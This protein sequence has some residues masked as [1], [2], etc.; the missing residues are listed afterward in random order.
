MDVMEWDGNDN[1]QEQQ[2][3]LSR[4]NAEDLVYGAATG[5]TS[6]TR[7]LNPDA[8]AP[9]TGP[10]QAPIPLSGA[11]IGPVVNSDSPFV[12]ANNPNNYLMKVEIAGI[13]DCKLQLLYEGKPM[14]SA[15][16]SG[17]VGGAEV[18][19]VVEPKPG[20]YIARVSDFAGCGP[21]NG[22]V[23]FKNTVGML[24]TKGSA[25]T[26]SNWTGKPTGWAIT[27]VGPGAFSGLDHSADAGGK[28]AITLDVV[29]VG[30]GE[31]DLSAGFIS[32]AT[33]S[34][35]GA[36]ALNTGRS[37][38]MTVPVFNNGGKAVAAAVVQVRS[39]SATGPVVATRTVAVP[40]YG[41]T[42]VA[43]AFT[44]AREGEVNLFTVV[45]PAGAVGEKTERNN[46]QRSTLWAGPSAPRVLVVDDDG[47]QDGEST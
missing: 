24:D 32:G 36:G 34:A 16:D 5:I 3:S 7:K 27:N 33:N 46:S 40:A 35:G 11:A 37:N 23:T 44:P 15:V 10:A 30:A 12:V 8:P 2:L 21:Y 1:T 20:N 42:D 18:I 17:S 4:G 39:G 29:K 45:D 25:D 43:F 31:S 19:Q 9:R 22:T 41:R 47:L 6:G 13:G 26:W 14:G 38:P 28:E